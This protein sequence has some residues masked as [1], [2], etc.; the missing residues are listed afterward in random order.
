MTFICPSPSDVGSWGGCSDR[1]ELVVCS[2][3]T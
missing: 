1:S 2:P 3:L